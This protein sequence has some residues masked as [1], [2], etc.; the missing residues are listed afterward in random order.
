MQLTEFLD[1]YRAALG[2]AWVAAST[3]DSSSLVVDP[4]HSLLRQG[5]RVD[6]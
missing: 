1:L 4:L 2:L 5:W 3:G 6:G